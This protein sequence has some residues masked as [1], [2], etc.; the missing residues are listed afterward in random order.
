MSAVYYTNDYIRSFFI[1]V[2]TW[3]SVALGVTALTA[4]YIASSHPEIIAQILDSSFLFFGLI[5]AQFAVVLWFSSSVMRMPFYP[6]L[7]LLLTYAALNGVTF[8]LILSA[9]TI[10][11]VATTFGITAATFGGMALFGR[12]T[13]ANLLTRGTFFYMALWGLILSMVVNIYLQNSMLDLIISCAGVLIFSALT[14]IDVQ[15]LTFI[16]REWEGRSQDLAQASLVGALTLYL[17]FINLFL[18]LLR[19]SGNRR[20]S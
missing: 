11:S 19:F 8:S 9:Y 1:S 4:G 13:R 15:R 18:M 3:M 14:A 17:D 6:A 16:A 12:F 20:N 2:F 7:L 10:E 5:L